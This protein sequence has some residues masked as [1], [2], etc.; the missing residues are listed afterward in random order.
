MGTRGSAISTVLARIY[1][2]AAMGYFVIRH[3]QRTRGA[4]WRVPKLPEPARMW[5]LLRIGFPA[6]GQIAFE[7]GVL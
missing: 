3:N 7:I 1:M 6:A 5:R 2:A 4:L